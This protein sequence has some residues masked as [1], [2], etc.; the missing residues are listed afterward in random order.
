M[1]RGKPAKGYSQNK[2]TNQNKFLAA[3]TLW[4]TDAKAREAANIGEGC[5]LS[6]ETRPRLSAKILTG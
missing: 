5:S 4:G 6:M 3:Y 1:P 2:F